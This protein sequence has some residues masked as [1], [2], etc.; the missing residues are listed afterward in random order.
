MGVPLLIC[1][2]ATEGGGSDIPPTMSVLWVPGLG[3]AS[4]EPLAS[5]LKWNRFEA[6]QKHLL[7]VASG[8]WLELVSARPLGA[9]SGKADLFPQGC[10][11]SSVRFPMAPYADLE[12]NLTNLSTL[13]YTNQ[14]RF[15]LLLL[16]GTSPVLRYL[17]LPAPRKS[18]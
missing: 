2:I 4:A 10:A 7:L 13:P 12:S 18:V 11:L 6:H 15:F 9:V 1:Q 5:I 8:F 16:L 17:T 3:A 14:C